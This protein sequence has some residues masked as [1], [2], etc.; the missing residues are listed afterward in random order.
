LLEIGAELDEHDLGKNRLT[1]EQLDALIG[2]RSY[3]DFLNS[4][5]EMYR[6]RKMK[7]NPPTRDEALTLM[8]QEPNLIRRPIVIRGGQMI[9]GYDEE[10]LRKLVK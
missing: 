6:Q 9:L 1:A 2:T 8:A 7:A 4:R 3:L 10:G 5:N